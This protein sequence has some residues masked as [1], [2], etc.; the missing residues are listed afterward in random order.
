MLV[1]MRVFTVIVVRLGKDS[2]IALATVDWT[3]I[4]MQA[5]PGRTSITAAIISKP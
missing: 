1:K 3:N 2:D 5:G 4:E